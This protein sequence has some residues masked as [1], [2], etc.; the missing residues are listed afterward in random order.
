MVSVVMPRE[1]KGTGK[2]NYFKNIQLL[3]DYLNASCGSRQCGLQAD[4]ADP[5]VWRGKAVG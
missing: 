1:D 3:V 2:S 5:H 4:E